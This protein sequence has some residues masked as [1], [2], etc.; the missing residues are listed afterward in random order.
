MPTLGWV[1]SAIPSIFVAEGVAQLARQARP[2]RLRR[3]F[4]RLLMSAGMRL[5][6]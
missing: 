3:A 2:L 1:L 4:A 5:L 6:F